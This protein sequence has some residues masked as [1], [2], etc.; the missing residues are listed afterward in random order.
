MVNVKKLGTEFEKEMV[1]ILAKDGW[2]S[3]FICPNETGAQP[4]DI[5]ACKNGHCIVGD[6][7]TSVKPIFP[8]SRL[9]DNQIMAF[10][11]WLA[12]G[13]SMPFVFVKYDNKIYVIEYS[14]LSK[15]GKIDLRQREELCVCEL[16]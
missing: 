15:I 14:E 10:E 13:N 6:C 11:K 2:W 12:C 8:I 3:H 5:I 16:L 4:F 9:E 1:N 7:K